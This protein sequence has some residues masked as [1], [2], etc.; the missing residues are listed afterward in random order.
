MFRESESESNKNVEII[1]A[2]CVPMDIGRAQKERSFSI[3][4]D[5][6]GSLEHFIETLKQR[7][8]L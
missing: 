1:S 8:R 4:R 6:R 5:L 3:E 7:Q 2:T